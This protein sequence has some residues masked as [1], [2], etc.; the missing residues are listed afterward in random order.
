M[1]TRLTN[2]MEKKKMKKDKNVEVSCNDK[3]CPFHGEKGKRLK[4]RGRTFEGNVLKKFHGRVVIEF[5]RMNYVR[6]YERYEK[7]K[8]KLHAR[9]PNC[10]D[11]EVNVGDR[12]RI[13]ETRPISKIIHFVVTKIVRKSE[14]G[15]K[16]ESS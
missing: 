10:L 16:N 5:D 4:L 12:V 11:E 3:L 13:V 8:T 14:Q 15:G 7:R 9:L 2:K 6:K 1:R